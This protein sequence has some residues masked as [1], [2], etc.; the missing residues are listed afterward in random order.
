MQTLGAG[1]LIPA[2]H[3]GSVLHQRSREY[4]TCVLELPAFRRFWFCS[5]TWHLRLLVYCA[6]THRDLDVQ[7]KCGNVRRTAFRKRYLC[8]FQL[9]LGY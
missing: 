4:C 8:L 2:A 1:S 9:P 5:A 3:H 7:R 6:A